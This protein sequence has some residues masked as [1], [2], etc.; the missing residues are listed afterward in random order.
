MRG[1]VVILWIAAICL[2]LAAAPCAAQTP[3]N[4]QGLKMFLKVDE[5]SGESQDTDHKDWIEVFHYADGVSQEYNP[6]WSP[7]SASDAQPACAPVSLFKYIDMSSPK[8]R[9]GSAT[10]K[11]FREVQ[12]E[13]AFNGVTFFKVKMENVMISI[14]Q[15]LTPETVCPA[16]LS[17]TDA[18]YPQ[19]RV[20]FLFAKITYTW[21][22]GGS[23]I[24][25]GYD[26]AEG[27]AVAAY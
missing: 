12:I 19:E 9:E 22:S 5:I 7:A 10:G 20:G 4:V 25:T 13:M 23:S 14:V 24:T 1:K 17:S 8:L 26:F 15:A 27:K 2:I 21:I 18:N 6:G 3:P 16:S 11:H